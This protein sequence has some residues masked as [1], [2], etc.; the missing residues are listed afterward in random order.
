MPN[1]QVAKIN[2][3]A[4]GPFIAVLVIAITASSCTPISRESSISAEGSV[5]HR[6]GQDLNREIL[7][8]YKNVKNL[9]KATAQDVLVAIV[10]KYITVGSTF[11][12]AETILKAADFSVSPHP[13]TYPVMEWPYSDDIVALLNVPLNRELISVTKLSINLRTAERLQYTTIRQVLVNY[14]ISVP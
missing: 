9:P 14:T 6:R 8:A 12:E 10:E 5:L 13:L 7:E 3:R 11:S 1:F 2:F 4:I